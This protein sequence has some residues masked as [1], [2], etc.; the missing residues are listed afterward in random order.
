V[1]YFST[2]LEEEISLV[3]FKGQ[4]SDSTQV[5]VGDIER[6]HEL[7]EMGFTDAEVLARVFGQK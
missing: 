5:T 7:S 4:N 6:A 3:A 1:I 2:V